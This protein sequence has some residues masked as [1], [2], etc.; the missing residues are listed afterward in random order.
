MPNDDRSNSSYVV[1]IP[2]EHKTDLWLSRISSFVSVVGLYVG[3]PSEL[4]IPGQFLYQAVYVMWFTQQQ[5]QKPN[6]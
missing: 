4:S 5:Q 2:K 1:E 6:V 3:L